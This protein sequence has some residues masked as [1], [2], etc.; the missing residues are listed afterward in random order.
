M[1]KT[2]W[3]LEPAPAPVGAVGQRVVID[4]GARGVYPLVGSTAKRSSTVT[5]RTE[6]P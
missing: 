2:S 6:T 3:G 5:T 4:F 1:A